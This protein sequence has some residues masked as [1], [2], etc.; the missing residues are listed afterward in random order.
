MKTAKAIL[1]CALAMLYINQAFLLSGVILVQT[2]REE[3][4]SHG[5]WTCL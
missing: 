5:F 2:E 3:D 1:G 4:R